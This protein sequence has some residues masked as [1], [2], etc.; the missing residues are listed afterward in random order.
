MIYFQTTIDILRI[1]INFIDKDEIQDMNEEN[2]ILATQMNG[3]CLK[4]MNLRMCYDYIN[5]IY[6]LVDKN[7]EKKSNNMHN[8]KLR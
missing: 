6:I 5:F 7:E 3:K 1:D 4:N 8:H 2:D